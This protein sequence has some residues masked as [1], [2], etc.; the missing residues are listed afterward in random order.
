MPREP[1]HDSPDRSGNAGD[2]KQ[3]AEKQ[4]QGDGRRAYRLFEYET[5]N[6]VNDS[7]DCKATVKKTEILQ[8]MPEH[9][10]DGCPM[11]EQMHQGVIFK[12]K[13]KQRR[14]K[15]DKTEEIARR[16]HTDFD[17][18]YNAMFPIPTS[19]SVKKSCQR[20]DDP[21][22]D[23]CPVVRYPRN[24]KPQKYRSHNTS[25]HVFPFYVC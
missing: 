17:T 11:S 24:Q 23:K 19:S 22:E 8:I 10:I 21:E 14:D 6:L 15:A 13:N 5:D 25:N 12:R 1:F 4:I 20:K 7:N 9:R 18:A 3:G 16:Q 2:Q